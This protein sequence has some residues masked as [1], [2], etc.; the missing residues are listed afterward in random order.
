MNDRSSP[1]T[2]LRRIEKK[3]TSL[4]IHQGM[5]VETNPTWVDGEVHVLSQGASVMEI[6]K[7]IPS[8]WSSDDAVPVIYRGQCICEVLKSE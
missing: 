1:D 5:D 7:V 2:R 4:M 6:L 8:Q 3:L